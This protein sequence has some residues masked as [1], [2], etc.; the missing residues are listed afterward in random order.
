MTSSRP[1]VAARIDGPRS[2]RGLLHVAAS[3]DP[4]MEVCTHRSEPWTGDRLV[5]SVR[6]PQD[7]QQRFSEMSFGFAIVF[8][9]DPRNVEECCRYIDAFWQ[10]DMEL[11]EVGSTTLQADIPEPREGL[12][13]AVG[14]LPN[15]VP[16]EALAGLTTDEAKALFFHRYRHSTR[17]F[18]K[19]GE[20]ECLDDLEGFVAWRT[21][22][23]ALEYPCYLECP[24]FHYS[25]ARAMTLLNDLFDYPRD[26]EQGSP[27]LVAHFQGDI[28]EAVRFFNDTLDRE[29]AL[30]QSPEAMDVY[31]RYF[32]W[33]IDP[34][35]QRDRGYDMAHYAEVLSLLRIKAPGTDYFY[36]R[37][38]RSS[39][40]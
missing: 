17:F 8:H 38:A 33:Q 2:V 21:I 10:Q 24:Q 4:G 20:R 19:G 1:A 9:K 12:A 39:A 28:V 34:K 7:E 26:A 18:R 36:R 14:T 35:A 3:L 32:Y 6:M 30:L 13:Q 25:L 27:N 37:I 29:T 40:P 23:G 15:P 11:D 22:N 31:H 5:S 16:L